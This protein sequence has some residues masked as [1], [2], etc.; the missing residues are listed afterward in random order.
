VTYWDFLSPITQEEY[1]RGLGGPVF[2]VAIDDPF[3]VA[4]VTMAA[5][6]RR[7]LA[8]PHIGVPVKV[9]GRIVFQ[10]TTRPFAVEE[11]KLHRILL[12]KITNKA[13]HYPKPNDG[14]RLWLL[15]WTVC[16][17]FF[18]FWN[19][20]GKAHVSPS[21]ELARAML[22]KTGTGPFDEV[23]FTDYVGVGMHHPHRVWPPE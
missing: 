20:G 23:W 22:A 7:P 6:A 15:I 9:A 2:S 10:P 4:Q 16:S 11:A 19:E 12:T 5:R 17:G 21:V 8:A 14:S 13:Q 18:A 1:D 3:A